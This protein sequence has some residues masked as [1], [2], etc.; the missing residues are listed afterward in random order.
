M[1]PHRRPA[2]IKST[3]AS[4]RPPPRFSTGQMVPKMCGGPI[5]TRRSRRGKVRD[6]RAQDFRSTI[7]MVALLDE[8]ETA[9]M[10]MSG[11]GVLGSCTPL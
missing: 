6:G 8:V 10:N 5:G 1:G 9:I 2:G 3:F 7:V 11:M 4:S